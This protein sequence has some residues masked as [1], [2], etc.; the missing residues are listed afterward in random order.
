[1]AA[2]GIVAQVGTEGYNANVAIMDLLATHGNEVVSPLNVTPHNF[3][4]LLKE[5]AGL[6]IIPSPTF[7]HSMTDLLD[8]INCTSPPGDWG[9]RTGVQ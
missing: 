8:M 6:A 7:E 3:L 5:V 2:K 9:R 1:M 4:V